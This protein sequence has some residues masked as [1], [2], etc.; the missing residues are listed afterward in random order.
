MPSL[1]PATPP[2]GPAP[3]RSAARMRTAT[4]PTATAPTVTTPATATVPLRSRPPRADRRSAARR[5]AELHAH[6]HPERRAEHRGRPERTRQPAPGQTS[7]R[8]AIR[9]LPEPERP[10]NRAYPGQNP[11][12]AVKRRRVPGPAR[13]SERRRLPGAPA[14]RRTGRTAS[15]RPSTPAPAIPQAPARPA[16]WRPST[17]RRRATPRPASSTR[18]SRATGSDL[19]TRPHWDAC[20]GTGTTRRRVKLRV[21][22]RLGSPGP[23]LISPSRNTVRLEPRCASRRG[24]DLSHRRY[25]GKP[26]AITVRGFL[27]PVRPAGG[28]NAPGDAGSQPVAAA[29]ARVSQRSRTVSNAALSTVNAH[30]VIH[31]DPASGSAAPSTITAT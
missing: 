31:A 19:V 25:I 9:R 12:R 6:L 8:P 7:R 1:A 18:P 20:S 11:A 5:H 30:A 3:S 10:A 24:G 16:R 22:V 23:H 4:A 29:R 2:A 15:R 26:L 27:F 28:G 14:L 21:P 13:L 17:R